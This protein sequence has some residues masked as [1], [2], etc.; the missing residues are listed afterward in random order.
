M[1]AYDIAKDGSLQ[2]ERIFVAKTDGV[3]DGLEVDE[4]GNVY[5]AAGR[6]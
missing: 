5:V 6:D 3:P 4:K 2:N 1:R